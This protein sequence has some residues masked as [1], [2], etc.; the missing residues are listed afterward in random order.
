MADTP[1][2]F[3]SPV[4]LTKRQLLGG[5]A[6]T[7]A[8]GGGLLTL[9]SDDASAAA[10]V[11]LGTVQVS[12]AAFETESVTPVVESQ[13]TY[14]YAVGDAAVGDLVVELLVGDTVV[15]DETLVTDTTSLRNDETLVG[16]VTDADRWS[17]SDFTVAVGESVTRSVTV[18]VRFAVRDPDGS[19]L[20]A[21]SAET[22]VDISVTHPRDSEWSVQVGATGVVRAP[23]N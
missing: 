7:A 15:A 16:R 22:V 4:S 2:R 5:L 1:S 18:G 14:D 17:A 13:V 9:A 8:G 23:E 6:A 3:D 21:A 10:S 12:D 20:E 11:E 19:V